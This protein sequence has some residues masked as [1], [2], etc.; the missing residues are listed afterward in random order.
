MILET[1]QRSALFLLAVSLLPVCFLVFRDYRRSKRAVVEGMAR[2]DARTCQKV[3]WTVTEYLGFLDLLL[4]FQRGWQTTGMLLHQQNIALQRV[5]LRGLPKSADIP[6]EVKASARKYRRYV[7]FLIAPLIVV[8]LL[9]V[10]ISFSQILTRLTGSTE[11]LWYLVF[12][13][14]IGALGFLPLEKF[15]KWSD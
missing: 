15:R 3:G 6:V 7:C 9:P 4:P 10:F 11:G 12:G 14:I 13:L 1:F 8:I 2:L 5:V